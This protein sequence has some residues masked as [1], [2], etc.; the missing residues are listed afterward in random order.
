MI[1][2]LVALFIGQIFGN[3]V[4]PIGTKI[5]ASFIGP[6]VFVF[7]RFVIATLLLSILFVFS[8][9]KKIHMQEYKDFLLLGFSLS[10]NVLMF[11]I[12]IS[13]TTVIMSTLIY[14]ITPVLVGILGHFYLDERLDKRKA[15][16]FSTAF[17]G[18]LFL[19]SNSFTHYASNV[20]G[21]PLGNF[22]IFIAML[23]YSY[24]VFYSRKV[25]YKKDNYPIQTTFLTFVFTTLILFFA[26]AIGIFTKHIAVH[27]ASSA[28][29]LGVFIV[30][31]GS[32]AQYLFL[33][34]GVKKTSA[35]IATLFQYFAPFIA[36][37][38]SVPLLHEKVTFQLV[39]GGVLVL[40]GV[41]LATTFGQIKQSTLS[42]ILAKQ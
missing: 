36:A 12:G 21:N 23:G 4:V 42:V 32:V 28:G 6:A 17:L 27:T 10:I 26:L 18:L 16:G 35:F 41:F 22:L 33:Q 37:A 15:I 2:G 29:I 40:L 25:L 1:A 13:Y 34:I 38:A 11:T 5:S 19:V 20:F 3:T 39:I 30:G 14:S 9:K 8:Q 7:L 31:S 24:Y